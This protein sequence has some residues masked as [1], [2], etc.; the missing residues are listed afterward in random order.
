MKVSKLS[1]VAS[2]VLAACGTEQAQNSAEPTKKE[3]A[4]QQAAQDEVR[5]SAMPKM[6]IVRVREDGRGDVL[7]GRQ[8]VEV[9]SI[10]NSVELNSNNIA[11]V[12]ASGVPSNIADNQ[13]DLNGESS[14]G[15]FYW[16]G[17]WGWG[18]NRP[19]WGWGHYGYAN[20]YRPN[21]W[22][23]GNSWGY[24]FN[25]Y[26]SWGGWRYYCYW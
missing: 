20:W 11:N 23:G 19:A 6:V 25:N 2:L 3:V 22:W 26:W 18:W 8:N 14:E 16:R 15:Q 24:G 12:F 7:A 1:L 13:D 17:H 9:R 10:A 5:P 4:G 21:W